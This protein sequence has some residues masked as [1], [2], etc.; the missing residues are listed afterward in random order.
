MRP[1][2]SV[3]QLSAVSVC[4]QMYRAV[5]IFLLTLLCK[6]STPL[7]PTVLGKAVVSHTYF[8]F[9]SQHSGI[10]AASKLQQTWALL[11]F[12]FINWIGLSNFPTLFLR[13]VNWFCTQI[14]N[15]S[16]HIIIL[17]FYGFSKTFLWVNWTYL[18]NSVEFTIF[19]TVTVVSLFY[20]R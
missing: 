9:F 11:A 7:V 4:S 16:F 10:E 13:G 19:K 14:L 20:S 2:E 3:L 5:I 6:M 12:Y 15:L 18:F 8:W 1:L 17:F